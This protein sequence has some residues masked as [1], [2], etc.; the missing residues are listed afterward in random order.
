M[1]DKMRNKLIIG[2][3]LTMKMA[4]STKYDCDLNIKMIMTTEN[5]AILT[6]TTNIAVITVLVTLLEEP[7][8]IC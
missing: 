5:N 8:R 2:T 4:K 6:T 3:V 1:P 7:V